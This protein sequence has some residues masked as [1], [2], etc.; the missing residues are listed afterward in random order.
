MQA[1]QIRHRF[2][3][4]HFH[5]MAKGGLFP[6]EQRIELIDGEVFDMPPIDP[7]HCSATSR[8][9]RL[10]SKLVGDE[11]IVSVQNALGVDDR[12]ELYPDLALLRWRDDFYA[13]AH[14]SPRDVLLLIEVADSSAATDREVK[15]PKYARCDIP[16][17][18]LLDLP[19]QRL[20]VY[21]RP[22][23]GEYRQILLPR[24]NEPL[25]PQLLPQ[26]ALKVADL[27][28]AAP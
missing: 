19:R 7:A 28:P 16:E 27:F 6:P 26:I 22:E 8:L 10:L 5:Q 23:E 25:S 13:K 21:R 3:I 1:L 17:V 15:V 9:N 12:S 14:P 18:W 24:P 2:D 11:V 4:H 20:E